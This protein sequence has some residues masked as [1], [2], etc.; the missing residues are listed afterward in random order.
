MD[1]HHSAYGIPQEQI[2]HYF[3][4]PSGGDNNGQE[5]SEVPPV[6]KQSSNMYETLL[7]SQPHAGSSTIPGLHTTTQEY[8]DKNLNLEK[9]AMLREKLL[10]SRRTTSRDVTPAD[11]AKHTQLSASPSQ[12]GKSRVPG[13]EELIR[14]SREVAE[15]NAMQHGPLDGTQIDPQQ[16]RTDLASP[17]KPATRTSR[18][19]YANGDM[20]VAPTT[21]TMT[22]PMPNAVEKIRR[23]SD[24]AVVPHP[25]QS[26]N[27]QNIIDKRALITVHKNVG[28]DNHGTASA[29]QSSRGVALRDKGQS[30]ADDAKSGAEQ[31]NES[32]QLRPVKQLSNVNND[33]IPSAG[34]DHSILS[35]YFSD[36]N[37]WLDITG[38]HDLSLRQRTLTR[39]RRRLQLEQELAQ[40]N[41][42]DEQDRNVA[43]GAGPVALPPAVS[44]SATRTTE[45]TS[46]ATAHI[47]RTV[48]TD[49]ST[50]IADASA[51]ASLPPTPFG[52][53]AHFRV[54][55]PQS[56]SADVHR[57]EK[58]QR[59]E[60]NETSKT[61]KS[62]NRP[63]FRAPDNNPNAR[64]PYSYSNRSQDGEYRRPS[65]ESNYRLP[66]DSEFD[67]PTHRASS[68]TWHGG[69]STSDPF[70]R[71]RY[72]EG[73]RSDAHTAAGG[74]F[75]SQRRFGNR[76]FGK[77][78]GR[79]ANVARNTFVKQP[80]T[81]SS[82]G[83]GK[84]TTV[85]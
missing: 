32:V 80:N 84:K 85:T 53:E 12:A 70:A 79:T 20:N 65:H 5:E 29:I 30:Q 62:F 4:G 68:H 75:S 42:E 28:N 2:I 13:L 27:G 14:E 9:A 72:P 37:E 36:L 67:R 49:L 56:A 44:S 54:K 51:I 18:H 59:T 73:G 11:N 71:D 41:Q 77:S 6:P 52:D 39:H 48:R 22:S 15:K 66:Y 82:K 40:L 19:E 10:A 46:G 35:K 16:Q 24:D 17:V 55:R 8:A 81:A 64:P 47:P 83:S 57:P 74:S 38:Y 78:K 33:E 25:S 7:A 34:L 60:A 58:Q 21:K 23:A 69:A 1:R 26:K 76:R 43:S 50:N 61:V 31:S 63:P 3:N 45:I